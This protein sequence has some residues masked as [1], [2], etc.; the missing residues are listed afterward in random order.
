MHIGFFHF[1]KLPMGNLPSSLPGNSNYIPIREILLDELQEFRGV[2][3]EAIDRKSLKLS[4]LIFESEFENYIPKHCFREII[5]NCLLKNVHYLQEPS[6]FPGLSSPSGSK[7][8]WA[9]SSASIPNGPFSA[10]R[11]GA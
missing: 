7:T 4:E 11:Y 6:S 2:I 3:Q 10:A 9:A 8:R 1:I 5:Q